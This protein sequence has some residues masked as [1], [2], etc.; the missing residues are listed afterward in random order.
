M[1]NLACSNPTLDKV[2]E[3][4][5]T[6]LAELTKAG[7]FPVPHARLVE[8]SEVPTNFTGR[9]GDI[10]FKRAWYYWT[11]KC[12]IP[13]SVAEQIHKHPS[14]NKDVRVAGHCGAP[15]P[16]EWAVRIDDESGKILTDD[17]EYQ[18]GLKLFANMGTALNDWT[19]NYMPEG[20]S[21]SHTSFITSYHID[22]QEGLDTF[23]QI[24]KESGVI[25]PKHS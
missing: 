17:N 5:E 19:T 8:H 14:C 2:G 10:T 22:T 21:K 20:Q 25:S 6:I 15:A 24:L 9:V 23:V 4:N 7:I 3:T 11:V 16:S 18:K 13:L 1:K 12:K